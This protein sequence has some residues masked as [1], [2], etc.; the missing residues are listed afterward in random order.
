MCSVNR[1]TLV[2][3]NNT[4]EGVLVS[5]YCEHTEFTGMHAHVVLYT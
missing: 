5:L 1:Y 3:E 2:N 4:E